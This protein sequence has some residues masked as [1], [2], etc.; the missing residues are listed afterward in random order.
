MN[1]FHRQLL[2]TFTRNFAIVL[3]VL[4][5]VAL[6]IGVAGP[7]GA[8]TTSRP[9]SVPM[10]LTALLLAATPAVLP[11]VFLIATLVTVGDL[12]RYGEIGALQA[13]GWSPLRIFMPLIAMGL[14]G[15]VA[16]AFLK[17]AASGNF[18]ALSGYVD[19]AALT[20]LHGARAATLGCLLAVLTA[21]PLAATM[22]RRDPFVG[23]GAALG[24]YVLHQIVTATAFAFGRH[25]ALPLMAGWGSTVLLVAVVAWLWRRINHD[26]P[27]R[28]RSS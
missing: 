7:D 19:R 25:G 15:S 9:G 5:P 2:V 17:P 1:P 24:I 22:R 23:F 11:L 18:T 8:A 13:A 12:A 4:T 6:G 16:S 27:R 26:P 3:L 21:V 20:A 14:A 28:H 10:T